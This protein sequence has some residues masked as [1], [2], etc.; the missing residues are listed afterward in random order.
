VKRAGAI[1]AL[2]LGLLPAR[3]FA[4]S[5]QACADAYMAGQVARKDGHLRDARTQF[6][7]CADD[8]CPAALQRDCK[9]WLEQIEH[10]IPT[11]A[12]AVTDAAGAALPGATVSV[13][14][15]AARA[16]GASALD[17]GAHVV[18]VEAPGMAAREERIEIAAGERRSM[19]LQLS[20]VPSAPP[21]PPARRSVPIAPIVV[22]ASGLV[23][24]GVFAGVG[25]AGNA[26]KSNLDQL[27]C[28]P[29]CSPSD[30]SA[31]RSLYLGADVAL[32]IG[33]AAVVAGAVWLGVKLGAPAPAA[34]V[35]SFSP[36]RGAGALTFHF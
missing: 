32:G 25:A 8:A 1:V 17:P 35:V 19:T 14:G 21:A 18:R 16:S 26:K 15:T 27:A 23:A 2:V 36:S 3:S 4:Q 24:L 5:K 31:G 33:L 7:L 34:E 30:V 13:D 10:D 22:A 29:N 20:R 12:V 28:K 9:P 6:T 11:L